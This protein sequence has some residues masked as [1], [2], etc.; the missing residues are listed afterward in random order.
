MLI[1]KAIEQR[2]LRF[3][4]HAKHVGRRPN[5]KGFVLKSDIVAPP[6]SKLRL[7]PPVW[8]NERQ[9]GVLKTRGTIEDWQRIVAEPARYSTRLM[10][11]ISVAFAAPLLKV[12]GMPNFGVNIHGLSKVGKTTG[13]LAAT[14]VIGIGSERNL[15]NWNTTSSA[16]LETARTFNDLLL[17]INEVGLL[18]GKK[19][20][21][22]GPIRERIYMFSEGN[23]RA[24][25]SSST[26]SSIAS[27]QWRGIFVST[28]EHSFNAYAAFS[29]ETRSEGEYA[30]C[31]DVAAAIK[32]K[33]TIF[34][35]NP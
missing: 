27:A 26:L 20:D 23:D 19:G 31:L 1:G 21:A 25:M 14:S 8:L 24:R 9:A 35:H 18:A 30:R 28:A 7:R 5:R 13:L 33:P 6:A 16:F 10:L 17:A 2:P 22:Y 3:E 4:L 12:T 32:G 29:G 34:D 15:P 11:L